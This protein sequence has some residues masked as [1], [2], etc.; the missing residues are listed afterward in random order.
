MTPAIVSKSACGPSP[1]VEAELLARLR[2]GQEAA[3]DELV[4]LSGG[5]MLAVA[6]RML[7][8]EADA[9]DAVQEAFL[10]AF[11]SLDRFDGRSQLNTW[12]HR[13][14]VNVCL[15]KLRSQRRRG[16]PDRPI[17]D[18]LPTFIADGH[19]TRDCISWKPDA[20]AGIERAEVRDLVRAKVNEL[21]EHYRVV[22][23]LRDIEELSTEETAEAL[24]MTINAVKTRL[25]RAR[26]ALRTL[27]DP[28]FSST[29]A[30]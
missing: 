9:E 18:F 24:G 8:R 28:H 26:Q 1:E 14:T 21:P 22:L 16:G 10:S 29:E 5:R 6:R 15:M 25:H 19:Q 30:P 13:I 23:M 3:Y 17:E 11:K 12:L 7:P 20:I 27:L 2:A 4:R